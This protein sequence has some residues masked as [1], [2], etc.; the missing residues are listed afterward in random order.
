MAKVRNCTV[1]IFIGIWVLLLVSGC[2]TQEHAT[3]RSGEAGE[4]GE[5]PEGTQF[6]P[7]GSGGAGA[8]PGGP[9]VGPGVPGVESQIPGLARGSHSDVGVAGMMSE[10]PPQ[11]RG[12]RMTK[13]GMETAGLESGLSGDLEFFAPGSGRAGAGGRGPGVGSGV[14]GVQSQ[15]PGLA[16]GSQS[17]LEVVEMTPEGLP[18]AKGGATRG[19]AP[20]SQELAMVSPSE[21]GGMPTFHRATSRTGLADVFFDYDQ[22][23]IRKDGV[24]TLEANA[25]LLKTTYQDSTLLVTGHCDERGTVEYNLVLGERRAQAVKDYLVDL[26]VPASRVK[27]ISY[28]KEKPFC[29]EHNVTC[30]QQ[31][32]RGHF[33]LR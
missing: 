6:F 13:S 24:S 27:V 10:A 2:G 32:R 19:M 18:H 29:A 20:S 4:A 23:L 15:I 14:P 33:V 26:G 8:R 7:S 3:V 16:Y 17:D 25:E 31:N 1:L 28:G 21:G 22:Y 5:A 11:P 9:G 12:S 30:W